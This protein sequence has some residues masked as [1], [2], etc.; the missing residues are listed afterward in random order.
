MARNIPRK[1]LRIARHGEK[2]KECERSGVHRRSRSSEAVT[3]PFPRLELE[4]LLETEA[5]EHAND[6]HEAIPP[7]PLPTTTTTITTEAPVVYVAPRPFVPVAGVPETSRSIVP[8][9]VTA[10]R[11]AQ[12]ARQEARLQRARTR[13]VVYGIWFTAVLLVSALGYVVASH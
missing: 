12:I 2:E 3:V 10:A 11:A 8:D 9:S 6:V 7:P 1:V 5:S 13:S 4:R